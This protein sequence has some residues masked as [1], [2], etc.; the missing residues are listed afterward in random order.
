MN[1]FSR[2]N[3]VFLLRFT[4]IIKSQAHNLI[5]KSSEVCYSYT[6]TSQKL[7]PAACE[8]ANRESRLPDTDSN[9]LFISTDLSYLIVRLNDLMRMKGQRSRFLT[10]END[11]SLS[12]LSEPIRVI[13]YFTFMTLFWY[14]II[15]ILSTDFSFHNISLGLAIALELIGLV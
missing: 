9:A 12:E 15:E 2:M 8:W 1:E 14:R 7:M 11:Q 3:I 5:I 4:K 6:Y 13:V 10:A